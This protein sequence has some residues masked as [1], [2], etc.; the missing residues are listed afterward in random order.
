MRHG[1]SCAFDKKVT[2][3]KRDTFR[4][5]P[6][7]P[8]HARLLEVSMVG[9]VAKLAVPFALKEVSKAFSSKETEGKDEAQEA[10]DPQG[11]EDQDRF[12][13]PSA[14]KLLGMVT[15]PLESLAGGIDK[16]IDGLKDA[17]GDVKDNAKYLAMLGLNGAEEMIGG[18][19]A[20][21]E[22]TQQP[23]QG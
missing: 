18:D 19:D 5:I 6:T 21:P 2:Q 1:G 11:N 17:V 9:L 3:I 4:E 23:G 22:G 20:Q 12:E 13:M 7:T 10:Q 8:V 14:Q 16:G 15:K